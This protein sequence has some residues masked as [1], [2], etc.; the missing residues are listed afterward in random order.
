MKFKIEDCKEALIDKLW[1]DM[2]VEYP[3]V[4]KMLKDFIKGGDAIDIRQALIHAFGVKPKWCARDQA[5]EF[6]L[7][8]P[9]EAEDEILYELWKKRVE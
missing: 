1:G 8:S 2:G 6:S 7:H 9:P 3:Y 4:F 5:F